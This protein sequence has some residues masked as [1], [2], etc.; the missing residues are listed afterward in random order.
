[1]LLG[2]F[3]DYNNHKVFGCLA[4]VHDITVKKENFSERCKP[5]VFLG[6]PM[7]KKGY[8]F[9]DLKEEKIYISRNATFVEDVFPF[10]RNYEGV[11]NLDDTSF[12]Q[13]LNEIQ[14]NVVYWDERWLKTEDCCVTKAQIET[15]ETL[16]NFKYGPDPD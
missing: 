11:K 14:K 9:F 7:G 13:N 6:Y 4:Y 2:K 3:P 15:K 8:K 5:C 10:K 1:M 12:A 16:P